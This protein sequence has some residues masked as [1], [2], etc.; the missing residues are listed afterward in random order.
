MPLPIAGGGPIDADV[1][2]VG[3]GPAGCALAARL[4]EDPAR[5]VLLLEAG[6][7]FTRARDFP[8]EIRSAR[9]LAATDPASP[10]NWAFTTELAPGRHGP[11]PRGRILGG[12]SAINAG[13]FVRGRPADFDG[14]A[15]AGNAIWSYDAVLPFFRRLEADADFGTLPGHG[16]AGPV[17]VRRVAAHDLHPASAAFAEAC[18]DAGFA[19]EPDKNGAGA[20]GVGPVPLT[21]VDGTRVNAAMAYLLP[22]LDRPNLRVQG[23]SVVH[24]VLLAGR[25][26]TGVEVATGRTTRVIRA[27]HVVLSAGAVKSP[28][29]LM[30]S[31]IGPAAQLRAQGIEVHVDLPGG[32]QGSS[33]H[34]SV[35]VAFRSPP[36]TGRAAS[37]AVEV[38]LNDDD[39]EILCYTASFEQ[40]VTGAGDGEL[41]L[42][43]GLQRCE[44]R[45]SMRLTSPD[46]DVPPQLSSHYLTSDVDRRRMR[47]AVRLAA[48]L[49]ASAPFRRLGASAPAEVDLGTDRAL[50]AWVAQN[51]STS[52]HLSGTCRMG[53]DRD[54]GAVVDELCRVRGIEGLRVVDTSIMPTVTT[55]GPYAT[56]I[57]IGERASDL[58][59]AP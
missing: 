43:V 35:A 23:G 47:A 55:R 57:M 1:V 16:D 17:P 39:V 18:R 29:L 27:D 5:S 53:P 19:A 49:L 31:G 46:P 8:A 7:A 10:L 50:D 30:V 28:H 42:G 32:G 40:L 21:V 2:V 37:S 58:F 45:G 15:A 4:S 56:A 6:P 34:P 41:A 33:D 26:A 54:A 38:A 36:A 14:W 3:A 51:L 22:H 44:A 12:S 59:A 20:E 24:R 52:V 11:V 48:A 9:S 13:Y 25:R